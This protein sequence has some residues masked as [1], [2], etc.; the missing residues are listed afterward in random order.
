MIIETRREEAMAP[1]S[2]GALCMR[3]GGDMTGEGATG[4]TK[5]QLCFLK[6]GGESRSA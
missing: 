3:E 4:N 5:W 1:N 6:L 2:E